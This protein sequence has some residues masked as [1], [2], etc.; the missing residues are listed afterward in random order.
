MYEVRFHGRGGQGAVMAAQA[1]ASA[2]FKEGYYAVAFPHFG[3]ERRGAPVLA[4][5]RM[6]KQKI[7]RKNQVYNPSFVVILDDRLIDLVNVSEGLNPSG[8]AVVNTRKSPEEIDLGMEIKVGVV[9]ATSVA[10]EVLGVPITNSAILGAF[11]K[12]TGVVSIE[13]VEEG[14]RDIFGGRIGKEAGEKNAKAARVA[15]DRTV[16]GTSRGEKKMVSKKQ[17]LPTV[18]ELPLGLATRS[19]ETD[20]GLVGPGSFVENKTGSW[21]TFKPVF[22]RDKCV[23]CLL[24]WFYCPEGAIKRVDGGKTLEF[25]F[26][27][28]KGCGICAEE[29]PTKAI[30]MVRD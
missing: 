8:A 14:I 28:C 24:C 16:V 18:Q 30:E 15:Y 5:T 25:D 2:A 6:D 22:N 1:L 27:Y 29:C 23:M 13:A 10:L 20:A 3:A 21:R 7:R 4:F 26:D 11:A 19:M 12:T 17:W 9:D